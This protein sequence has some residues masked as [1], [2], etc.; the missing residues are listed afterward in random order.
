LEQKLEGLTKSNPWRW[1]AR[2]EGGDGTIIESLEDPREEEVAEVVRAVVHNNQP[3]GFQWMSKVVAELRERRLG[4]RR[5]EVLA[6]EPLDD[7][8]RRVVRMERQVEEAALL[9]FPPFFVERWALKVEE[10]GSEV[11]PKGSG[12]IA[13]I[14]K[15]Q[16]EIT[17]CSLLVFPIGR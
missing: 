3:V 1:L 14:G 5:E 17:N 7:S 9:K 11:R 13:P 6:E 12:G 15:A 4:S 16:E 8:R 10:S 2:E